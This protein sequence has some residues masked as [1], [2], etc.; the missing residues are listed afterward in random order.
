MTTEFLYTS[1]EYKFHGEGHQGAV[2]GRHVHMGGIK[3]PYLSCVQGEG[4]SKTNAT[5]D[6]PC[7]PKMSAI[8]QYLPIGCLQTLLKLPLFHNPLAPDPTVAMVLFHPTPSPY[9]EGHISDS[10][11]TLAQPRAKKQKRLV[12]RRIEV[13]TFGNPGFEVLQIND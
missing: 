7:D 6:W 1:K 8:L 9:D 3:G 13:E 10:L 5:E 4:V 2:S 11:N 12:Q